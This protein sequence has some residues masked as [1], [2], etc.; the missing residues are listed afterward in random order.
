MAPDILVSVVIPTR[1]RPMMLKRLLSEL[2]SVKGLEII[3]VDDC[4]DESSARDNRA[5]AREVSNAMYVAQDAC[6]GAA[7]ARNIGAM[8]AS[9]RYLWFIDDDDLVHAAVAHAVVERLQGSRRPPLAVMRTEFVFNE[10]IVGT[11]RPTTERETF[12][13]YRDRGQVASLPSFV[14]ERELFRNAGGWDPNFSAA[15]DTD[16]I[17]RLS[18]VATPE[19]WPDLAVVV[20]VGHARRITNQVLRQQ[21][22]KLK[23]L[24]KHW[25]TLTWRRRLYYLVTLMIWMPLVRRLTG[26]LVAREVSRYAGLL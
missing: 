10:K 23:M 7:A 25:R 12:E 8:R 24:S 2:Q 3:I 15:Q 6:Y 26:R 5:A 16:L 4:S 17:L 13:K 22:A 18:R 1:N 11:H 9:G 20:H 21:R 19:C 14:I